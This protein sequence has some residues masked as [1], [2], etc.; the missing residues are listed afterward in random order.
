MTLA[1]GT[2]RCVPTQLPRVQVTL[3]AELADA[4]ERVGSHVATRHGRAGLIRE[5]A[6]RGAQT[7][8]ADAERRREEIE[9]FIERSTAREPGFDVEIAKHVDRLGWGLEPDR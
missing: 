9:R 7:V 4:L 6:L 5:L 2:L 3:D 8:E 1:G